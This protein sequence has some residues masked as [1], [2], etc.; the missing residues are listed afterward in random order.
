MRNVRHMVCGLAATASVFIIDAHAADLTPSFQ[1]PWSQPDVYSDIPTYDWSG[2]Y[3]AIMG[4]YNS[5]TITAGN[6]AS[7]LVDVAIPSWKYADKAKAF[8]SASVQDMSAN[9]GVY[10]LHAGINM[11]SQRVVYGAEIEYGRFSP[12]MNTQGAF[13]DAREID[14]KSTTNAA[15]QTVDDHISVGLSYNNKTQIQDFGLINARAGYA[16]GRFM[17]YAMVGLGVTRVKVAASMTAVEIHRVEVDYVYS[18]RLSNMTTPATAVFNKDA[19]A[20][21]VSLGLGFEYAFTDNVILRAQYNYM[22]AGNVKGEGVSSN[23]A[24]GGLAL[25]F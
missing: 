25:K 9:A 13:A 4:G 19:Y 23:L 15:G 14:L 12:T 16:Y 5:S 3:V 24:R 7:N 8:A 1:W 10:S 6:L 20:A 2:G 18:S 22:N 17:P 21:T 11:M